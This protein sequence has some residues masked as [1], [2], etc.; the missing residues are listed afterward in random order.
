[1]SRGEGLPRITSLH[2]VSEDPLSETRKLRP[3]RLPRRLRTSLRPLRSFVCPALPPVLPAILSYSA[4]DP[5]SQTTNPQTGNTAARFRLAWR[6]PSPDQS[7]AGSGSYEPGGYVYLR[8]TLQRRPG[9][10]DVRTERW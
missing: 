3:R 9:P 10:Q 2:R 4:A 7:V 8:N 1:M 6:R 5:C